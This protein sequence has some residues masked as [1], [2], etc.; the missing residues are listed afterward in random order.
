MKMSC[1]LSVTTLLF[2]LSA[3]SAFA[4]TNVNGDLLEH[5]ETLRSAMPGRDSEGFVKPS[6]RDLIDWRVMIDAMVTASFPSYPFLRFTDTGTGYFD[7]VYYILEETIPYSNGWGVVIM[8]PAYGRALCVE[9]PL[10]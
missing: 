9:S 4:L 7:R 5:V 8:N 6:A 10:S 3:G 2:Y 1:M